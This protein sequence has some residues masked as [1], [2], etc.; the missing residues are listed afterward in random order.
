MSISFAD[1][2]GSKGYQVRV[3]RNG[4][5]YSKFFNANQRGAKKQAEEYERQLLE[6]LGPP[7]KGRGRKRP[8][9]TNTG[10]RYI[11]ETIGK[12]GTSCF[13]VTYREESGNWASRDISIDHN[14][15]AAALRRAKEIHRLRHVPGESDKLSTPSPQKVKEELAS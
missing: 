10:M 5:Q 1:R 13:R 11:S 7:S 12:Y 6:M 2:G 3:T 8:V 9:R 4:K 15:R 14:G